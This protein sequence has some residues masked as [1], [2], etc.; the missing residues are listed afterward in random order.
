MIK[1]DITEEDKKK[2][3]G[4]IGETH[5]NWMEVDYLWVDEAHRKNHIGS[6]LLKEAENLA[7]ERGCT[8]VFLNTFHFQ[9]PEFYKKH[10]YQEVFVL[11]NYPLTGKRHY[12]VKNL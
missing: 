3:A 11:E 1:T 8:N 7:I 10:G 6:N 4:I 2:I 9:A 5:G 12:Y